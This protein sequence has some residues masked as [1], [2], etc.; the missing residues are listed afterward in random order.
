MEKHFLG[1]CGL[2]NLHDV[3]CVLPSEVRDVNMIPN[4]YKVCV[5]EGFSDLRINC[6]GGL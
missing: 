6:V 1:A 4:L 3:S 2:L 5:K